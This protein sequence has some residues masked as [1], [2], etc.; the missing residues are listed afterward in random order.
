MSNAFPESKFSATGELRERPWFGLPFL[1]AVAVFLACFS[2]PD[3]LLAEPDLQW[4]IA[5]GRWMIEHRKFM[6]TDVFSYTFAGQPWISTAW[7]SQVLFAIVYDFGGWLAILAIGS[8]ATAL[9]FYLIARLV[10]SVQGELWGTLT[11]MISYP[12]VYPAITIRPH[13]L[14]LPVIVAWTTALMSAT[15]KRHPPWTALSLMVLW[16]NLHGAFTVGF[17]IAGAFGLEA[18]LR[19]EPQDRIRVAAV[20]CIFGA[21]AFA[22]ACA[23]PSGI[24]PFILTFRLAHANEALP[25]TQEWRSASFEATTVLF[26]MV[27]VLYMLALSKEVRR[28]AA[29]ILLIAAVTLLTLRYMRFIMFLGIVA[30][31]LG[32]A[33]M[34]RIFPSALKSPLADRLRHQL[35]GLALLRGACAVAAALTFYAATQKSIRPPDAESPDAAFASVPEEIRNKRVLNSFHFGGFLIRHGIPTF[36]DGRTDMLFGGGFVSRY[37]KAREPENTAGVASLVDEYRIEW[38]IVG[39]DDGFAKTIPQLEGWRTHYKDDAATVFIR[40]QK[41][42]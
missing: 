21:L 17:I 28:N 2:R 12:L 1:W 37:L 19:A 27:P 5:A 13:L 7:F 24:H 8:L 30:P 9:A 35:P 14:A 18:L 6:D 11:S 29:R 33:A 38:A 25:H 40:V 32:S 22:A 10:G 41:A 39:T 26:F 3:L 34:G 15:G 4:H 42:E 23:T 16:A 36:I 31:L 20:W